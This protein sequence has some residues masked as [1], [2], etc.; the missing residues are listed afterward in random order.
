M[1]PL[2]PA[3]QRVVDVMKGGVMIRKDNEYGFFEYVWFE[4]DDTHGTILTAT[5]KSLV[6]NGI[7]QYSY[8]IGGYNFYTLSPEYK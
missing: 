2:T 6:S 4:P 1:K 5:G 7:V 8:E 3:Q